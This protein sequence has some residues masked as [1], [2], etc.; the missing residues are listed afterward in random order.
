MRKGCEL[1]VEHKRQSLA[2]LFFLAEA[3][4]LYLDICGKNILAFLTTAY[5][6]SVIVFSIAVQTGR[7]SA[8]NNNN[9]S[10]SSQQAEG[11]NNGR[12]KSSSEQAEEQLIAIERAF[13]AIQM[14]YTFFHLVLALASS[15]KINLG[16][17]I[18][19]LVYSAIGLFFAFKYGTQITDRETADGQSNQEQP[20]DVEN[21]GT[22][23]T[24]ST[25]FT[26]GD[27]VSDQTGDSLV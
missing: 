4:A 7:K 16:F 21:A 9:R 24:S 5:L 8:R 19:P 12:N 10:P 11:N 17:S 27:P 14:M 22:A 2:L 3:F 1:L 15:K 26:S 13:A 6:L 20:N 25:I 18:F 23:S